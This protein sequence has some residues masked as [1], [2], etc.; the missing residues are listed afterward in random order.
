MEA[1]GKETKRFDELIFRNRNKEYGA[2]YLR[3]IY[4]RTLSISSIIAFTIVIIAV[5][6]PCIMAKIT[7]SNELNGTELITVI[8]KLSSPDEPDPLTPPEPPGIPLVNKIPS[9]IAPE[10][11]DKLVTGEEELQINDILLKTTVNVNTITDVEMVAKPD[12]TSEAD[13]PLVNVPEEQPEFPGGSDSL[14]KYLFRSVIY[15]RV[16]VETGV[17]GTVWVGFIVNQFGKV[18]QVN[19]LRG[20]DPLLD[21]EALRVIESMPDW[22]PGRQGGMPVKVKCRLPIKFKL[23]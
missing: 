2:F 23:N 6:A 9:Y 19:L 5:G 13:A 18:V 1:I 17:Q 7:D 11:T 16:A 15:P 22:Q 3:K 21:R 4:N 20:V 8:T 12:I 10:V 14:H